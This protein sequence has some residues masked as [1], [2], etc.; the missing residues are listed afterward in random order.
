MSGEADFSDSIGKSEIEYGTA[1]AYPANYFT[2]TLDRDDPPFT[3]GDPLPPAWHYFYFHE[4]VALAATGEDGH[5]AKG[6]FMPP[7]PFP[8]RMWAGSKMRFESPIRIGEK[9]RKV[10]TIADIVMKEGKSGKMCFVTTTEEVF[11]ED[12]RL[13]TSETRTQVYREPAGVS[14]APPHPRPAPAVAM[15]SRTVHPN[16]VMLF[17]YSALTMNSHRIHYDKDY[18][19]DVEGYPGLL[20]HGPLTMTFM[21]DLF[22]REMPGAT[23]TSLDLRAVSPV[24]DTMDFSVHG[25]PGEGG[26]CQL[27][28]MNGNGA[29]AMVADATYSV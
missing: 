3:N 10:I 26:T 18:V 9:L 7:L 25:T 13:T 20:V 1:S 12:G 8:R 15:W 17:R 16:S 11:G 4:L 27:W 6:D 23:M 2:L 14:V 22:R 28:A 21:L 24:Y 29:L 19:R 5:R